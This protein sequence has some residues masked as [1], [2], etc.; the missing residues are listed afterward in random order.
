M[1]FNT[2]AII[3][4]REDFDGPDSRL[5]LLSETHG[6]LE[7]IAKGLRRAQSKL[8]AHTQPGVL[9]DCFIVQGRKHKLFAGSVIEEHYQVPYQ[10]LR[11]QYLSGAVLRIA[12]ALLPFEQHDQTIFSKLLEALNVIDLTPEHEQVKL[13]PFFYA[14]QLVIYSGY[15]PQLENCVV[16]SKNLFNQ[17]KTF[18]D[19]RRGGLIHDNCIDNQ[20]PAVLVNQSAIKGLRYMTGASLGDS[21]KLRA[22]AEI[23][24]QICRVI[25]EVVEERFDISAQGS[26]WSFVP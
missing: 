16:C 11:K 5:Y 9:A 1:T 13:V 15:A 7:L 4:R 20:T 14:W 26:F 23:F 8:A 17:P 21:L 22:E 12:D 24:E 6:K 3:L 10:S 19:I 25:K 18:L 2:R